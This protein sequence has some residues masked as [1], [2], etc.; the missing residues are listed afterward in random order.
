MDPT[1]VP[2]RTELVSVTSEP[3]PT[4]KP[5]TTHFSEVLATGAG[6]LARGA[7]AAMTALPGGVL[8]AA[9]VRAGA[10]PTQTAGLV[11]PS[12]GN[13]TGAGALGTGATAVAEGPGATA[14]AVTGGDG[15]IESSL[16]QS[17][18][19]NLYYLQVQQQVNQQSQTFETL[20]NVMKSESDTV[21]NA[22]GNMH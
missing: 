13:L 1:I 10:A 17:Q 18:Q 20:S 6:G 9:A 8:V 3:R 21:K 4:P 19:S 22:I 2:K 12:F 15:G 14:S 7:E 16:A 5:A 11:L